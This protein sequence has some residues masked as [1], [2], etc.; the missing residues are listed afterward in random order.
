MSIFNLKTHLWPSFGHY[1]SGLVSPLSLLA[2]HIQII[3]QP[4]NLLNDSKAGQYF[5]RDN[6]IP[7]PRAATFSAWRSL[8]GLGRV[9]SPF[10]YCPF[11][12]SIRNDEEGGIANSLRGAG[13]AGTAHLSTLTRKSRLHVRDNAGRISWGTVYI[14]QWDRPEHPLVMAMDRSDIPEST[15]L[16][17]KYQVDNSEARIHGGIRSR[18]EFV[19]QFGIPATSQ[20]DLPLASVRRILFQTLSQNHAQEFATAMC[21]ARLDYES[22][23]HAEE[24]DYQQMI[25]EIRQNIVNL[26]MTKEEGV[27]QGATGNKRRVRNV[28]DLEDLPVSL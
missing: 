13:E 23:I 17:R 1:N 14:G 7:S 12:P 4:G 20:S 8:L 24:Q 11:L 26:K 5:F 25:H 9:G 15:V 18:M 2:F 21:Q 16:P 3:S 27:K 10:F 19:A 6:A 28:F 22:D